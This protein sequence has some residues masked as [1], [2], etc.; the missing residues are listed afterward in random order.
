[1]EIFGP[2]R[3]GWV[4]LLLIVIASTSA[5]ADPAQLS[6]LAP[7]EAEGRVYQV[8]PTERQFIGE[9]E[10][11]M[12]VEKGEGELDTALF[13]C[14]IVHEIETESNRTT[15]SG[16]CHIVATRGN[17]YGKFTCTGEPGHCD[18]Q[19]EVTGGTEEFERVSGGGAIRIRIALSV[20]ATDEASG[21]IV[22]EAKGL[23]IWPDLA[24]ALPGQDRPGIEK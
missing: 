15:A 1:M 6:I 8:G 22:A 16:R 4:A 7:W 23:A 9:I 14:P 21:E 5:A 11:I 10:G 12:Y 2:G 24:L 18:G 17:V 20:M 19:F 13:V 3:S